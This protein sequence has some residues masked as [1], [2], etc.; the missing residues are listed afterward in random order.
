MRQITPAEGQREAD[1]PLYVG[2]HRGVW[3]LPPGEQP[4]QAAHAATEVDE[5]AQ[6]STAPRVPRIV[7][8]NEAPNYPH[9]GEED[10]QPRRQRMPEG[11]LL[12][13]MLAVALVLSIPAILHLLAMLGWLP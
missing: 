10:G 9:F 6:P 1:R 3:P 2:L 7:R 13:L 8:W 11:G 12:A 5:A 4:P